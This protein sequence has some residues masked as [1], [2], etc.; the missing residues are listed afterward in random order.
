MMPVVSGALG[1]GTQI[2]VVR[3]GIEHPGRRA[4]FGDTLSPEIGEMRSN[5][6]GSAETQS[7][8]AG[9][10]APGAHEY[11]TAVALRHAKRPLRRGRAPVGYIRLRIV[12]A[13]SGRHGLHAVP[14][15]ASARRR[16][17]GPAPG[18]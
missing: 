6:G 12:R 18:S 8:D 3:N 7:D 10:D 14:R 9:F 4:V 15:R 16:A 2:G 13:S 5:R 11:R 1:E 17:L